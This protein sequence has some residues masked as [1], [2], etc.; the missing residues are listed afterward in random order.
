MSTSSSAP[1]GPMAPPPPRKSSNVV[2]IVLLSLALIVLVCVMAVWASLRF[3]ARGVRVSVSDQGVAK[4]AVSI[5]TPFGGIQVN[6]NGEVSEATLGLPVYPGATRERDEDSASVSLGLP[7]D[8]GL[9]L[10]V[11]KYRTP[12]A[13]EKVK[14]FYQDRIGKD[15]TKFKERDHEGKTVFEIKVGDDVKVVALKGEFEGTRIDLV[16]VSAGGG[17]VD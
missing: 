17:E 7:G 2:P 3:I 11:A 5:Q 10:A 1:R 8:T 16:H 13:I 15:V 6:K 9:H 4:K 14:A 12:D